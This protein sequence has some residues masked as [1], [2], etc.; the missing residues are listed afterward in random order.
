MLFLN[1]VVIF[2]HQDFSMQVFF[3]YPTDYKYTILLDNEVAKG[4]K[5]LIESESIL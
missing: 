1:F 4:A 2:K 3:Y 5:T